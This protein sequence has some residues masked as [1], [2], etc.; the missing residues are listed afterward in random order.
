MKVLDYL[1]IEPREIL[2]KSEQEYKTFNLKDKNI[3]N[4]EIV[5]I[6]TEN[7]KLIER[8]IVVSRGKAII[9]RPPE[10]VLALIN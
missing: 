10:N 9:G 7:P 5:R 6:M 1:N 4:S 2:R 3:D 8:P